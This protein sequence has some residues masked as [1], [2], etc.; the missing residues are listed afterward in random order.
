MKTETQ[1]RLR[2]LIERVIK[3]EFYKYSIGKSVKLDLNGSNPRMYGMD[4]SEFSKLK[5]HNGQIAK[6]KKMNTS[7]PEEY[8]YDLEFK[9]GY[10]VTNLSHF[11]ITKP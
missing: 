5:A 1:Q 8:F 4:S 9:D 10:V 2:K 11:N 7:D 3:E 6:I